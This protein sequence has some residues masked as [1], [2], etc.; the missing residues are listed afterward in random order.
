[1]WFA[2]TCSHSDW[3]RGYKRSRG[4]HSHDLEAEFITDAKQDAVNEM[5]GSGQPR[6]ANVTTGS[7]GTSGLRV[8]LP[9]DP[10][11][12]YRQI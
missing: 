4:V 5:R 6:F 11:D 12:A 1:M 2:V 3:Q 7:I 9:N 8:K 10:G